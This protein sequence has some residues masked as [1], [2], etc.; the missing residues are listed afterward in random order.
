MSYHHLG[1]SPWMNHV[2]QRLRGYVQK[3]GDGEEKFPRGDIDRWNSIENLVSSSSCTVNEWLYP[4][5]ADRSLEGQTRPRYY[6]SC[7]C[8]DDE[9]GDN[10]VVMV[11]VVMVMRFGLLL[12]YSFLNPRSS[13][14]TTSPSS[15][16]LKTAYYS[17]I[18]Q[19]NFAW[20]VGPTTFSMML[21]ASSSGRKPHYN[22]YYVWRT[23]SHSPSTADKKMTI[24]Y[25][26]NTK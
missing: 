15:S 18:G 12:Y 16:S 22:Y 19:F 24:F 8:C 10:A 3:G 7:N 9:Y 6:H 11:M 4:F 25:T 1:A 5:I 17:F 26:K 23:L 13:E 14:T 21:A 2:V 20:Y